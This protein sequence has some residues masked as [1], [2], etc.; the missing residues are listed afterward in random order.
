MVKVF[1]WVNKS[2]IDSIPIQNLFGFEQTHDAENFMKVVLD[3]RVW[4]L[5]PSDF[6][7]FRKTLLK[8]KARM[9]GIKI[10]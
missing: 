2:N 4:Q 9:R 5:L 8:S 7:T 1:G 6:K 10:T 3:I